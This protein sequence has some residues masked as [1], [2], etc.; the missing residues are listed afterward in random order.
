MKGLIRTHLLQLESRLGV[1][2]PVGHPV[3]AWLA[4]AC[5]DM[6]TKYLKGHDGKT[7]FERLYGKTVREEMLSFG[8]LVHWKRAKAPDVHTSVEARWEEGVWLGRRWGSITHLIGFGD[9]VE[10]ARAVMRKPQ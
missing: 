1:E 5:G 7:G 6:A 3:F 9:T 10:E 8:E 2:F 4:E